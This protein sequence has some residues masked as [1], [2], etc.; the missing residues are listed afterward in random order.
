MVF[1]SVHSAAT[2]VMQAAC[3]G[4]DDP[5][6][7][8]DNPGKQLLMSKPA[9]VEYTR[10]VHLGHAPPRTVHL[11]HAPPRTV[12]LGH[13]PPRTVHLGHDPPPPD[14][15]TPLPPWT[16]HLGHAPPCW[17]RAGRAAPASP[18]CLYRWELPLQHTFLQAPL[19]TG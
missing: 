11:G 1:I 15:A 17:P 7:Q 5:E 4:A 16:V 19:H 13:A 10:T 9:S 8:Q 12:H 2:Q 18:R 6:V 14:G 3:L